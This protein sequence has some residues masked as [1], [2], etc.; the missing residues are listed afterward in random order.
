MRHSQKNNSEQD[1]KSLYTARAILHESH[2]HRR[3]PVQRGAAF[4]CIGDIRY[5]EGQ[6]FDVHEQAPEVLSSHCCHVYY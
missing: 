1:T 3:H 5:N 2:M 4:R 6:L